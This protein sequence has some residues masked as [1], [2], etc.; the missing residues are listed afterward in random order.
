M[1]NVEIRHAIDPKTAKAFDT[2][3]MREHF[4]VGGI[5]REG[6]INLIY[7]HYDRMIVGGAVPA[8]KRLELDHVKPCGTASILDRRELVVVNIGAEG[9]VTA[10][11]EYKMAKGDMLYLGMGSGSI[12]FSGDGR[13]YILSAPAHQTYPSRLIKIDEAASISLGAQETSNERT[14]YQ[15]VHPEVMKSCQLVVGMT[16]LKNGSVWNTMPAHVHD[17]RMEAYL[18]F[19][20]ADNQRVFHM[21][22]EPE[23]TRHLVLKNEE[24]AISPPWSI[25]SGAGTG[26]Y[27]FI[28]AMAGDNVDYKDVEMVSMETLK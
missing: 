21:M 12:E 20:L 27:T 23:E 5:F 2:K 28:W 14:I 1:L 10:G 11:T 19:D 9:I 18:Y 26:S 6:E 13:F 24:G 25:H 22:G 16:K 17:R 15:F 4:H 3:A 7:T 8:G